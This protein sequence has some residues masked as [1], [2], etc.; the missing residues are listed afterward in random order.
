MGLHC[1]YRGAEDN[2]GR[3]VVG[4]TKDC[5]VD[6][7]VAG[8]SQA[9][10]SVA[11]EGGGMTRPTEAQLVEMEQRGRWLLDSV[12]LQRMELER[13]E[14]ARG[15]SRRGPT[16]SDYMRV[17]TQE[18]IARDVLLLVGLV[19]ENGKVGEVGVFSRAGVVE[20]PSPTLL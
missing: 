9:E 17:D 18:V 1:A 15:G 6:R 3:S 16:R 4:G 14:M 8:G 20:K 13:Q 19:R 11:A 2:G 12:G 5:E 10:T 7:K